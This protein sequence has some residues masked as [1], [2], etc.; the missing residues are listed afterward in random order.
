MIEAEFRRT[1]KLILNYFTP[2]SNGKFIA[3]C[4]MLSDQVH[5]M[6]P[7][8]SREDRLLQTDDWGSVEYSD[9][10]FWWLDHSYDWFNSRDWFNNLTDEAKLAIRSNEYCF[11]TCHEAYTVRYMKN[12]FPNAKI[13]SIIPDLNCTQANFEAKR[14]VSFKFTEQYNEFMNW[15]VIADACMFPQTAIYNT[16]FENSFMNLCR[17]LGIVPAMEKVLHYRQQYLNNT[18]MQRAVSAMKNLR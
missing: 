15:E 9:V 2:F 4:L 8:G 18:F 10:D 7:Q 14:G 13:M 3:S 1:D 6:I 17:Q 12:L 16:D 5:D 11:Y